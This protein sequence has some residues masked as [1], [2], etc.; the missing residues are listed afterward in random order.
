MEMKTINFI[1][2][3]TNKNNIRNN[4][5]SFKLE[6]RKMEDNNKFW[7]FDYVTNEE[8]GEVQL[9]KMETCYLLG[10][11]CEKKEAVVVTSMGLV[12]SVSI[13]KLMQRKL[14]AVETYQE[15]AHEYMFEAFADVDE[16]EG[17]G[18]DN[19]LYKKMDE[20]KIK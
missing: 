17:F 5:V 18:I 4:K 12:K 13:F 7:L 3:I 9:T 6:S 10:T 19:E 8:R 16:V 2:R 14:L 15:I 11:S 1:K 20:S